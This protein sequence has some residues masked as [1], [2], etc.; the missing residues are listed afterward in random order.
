MNRTEINESNANQLGFEAGDGGAYS[1][2][3]E[4]TRQKEY[5]E[6]YQAGYAAVQDEQF[7]EAFYAGYETGY[8]VGVENGHEHRCSDFAID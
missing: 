1:R 6:G 2:S 3:F 7:E 5:E 8:T 4:A